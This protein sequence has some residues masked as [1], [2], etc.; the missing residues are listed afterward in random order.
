M[1]WCTIESDPGVFTELIHNIGCTDVQLE[2]V[3]TLDSLP[4]KTLGLIFLFKFKKELYASDN[5]H[6]ISSQSNQN[7]YFARQTIQN[8]CATQAII[9]ILLNCDK[10][11]LGDTLQNFKEFTTTLPYDMRGDMIGQ[12]EL[13]RAKHNSFARNDPFVSSDDL[14]DKDKNKGDAFHFVAYTPVNGYVYEL[15]GLRDGPILID[16]ISGDQNW[17]DIAKGE[18]QRRISQ[19]ESTEINFNLM[20]VVENKGKLAKAELTR[21]ETIITDLNNKTDKNSEDEQILITKQNQKDELNMLIAE[22]Q[23]KYDNYSKENKRRRHNYIPFIMKALQGMAKKKILMDSLKK[24][25][26]EIKKQNEEKKKMM[27]KQK[28]ASAKENTSLS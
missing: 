22:E 18:I 7:V 17:I 20:A 11:E 2:E 1:D 10:I 14:D 23:E 13:I 27:T 15:D 16:A 9:N 6:G 3:I 4:S 28:Q 12:Q 19:F 25:L 26:E 5:R 21:V 8:A 24:G